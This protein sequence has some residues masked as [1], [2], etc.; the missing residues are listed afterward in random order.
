MFYWSRK[1][2]QTPRSAFNTESASVGI[3]TN[4]RLGLGG[5]LLLL[6][7]FYLSKE[8]RMFLKK[9]SLKTKETF[10]SKCLSKR[11]AD[12]IMFEVTGLK[13]DICVRMRMYVHVCRCVC[14]FIKIKLHN[15]FK[16]NLVL[17]HSYIAA[18]FLIVYNLLS[19]K[20]AQ[21]PM[22][23]HVE[24]LSST[25]VDLEKS[26]SRGSI[27]EDRSLSSPPLVREKLHHSVTSHFKS[28]SLTKLS[29]HFPLVYFL[30]STQWRDNQEN[31]C[32]V[33]F[34]Q[35]GPALAHTL[36]VLHQLFTRLL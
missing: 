3:W 25:D 2:Q 29:V 26:L 12:T 18:I 31:V 13:L 16:I 5:L 15:I 1:D 21:C 22:V 27:R 32:H 6:F 30:L 35:Q 4:K 11:Q 36:K 17:W 10:N 20:R 34:A 24:G 14:I 19:R 9:A 28:T 23:I 33:D 8:L 7:I